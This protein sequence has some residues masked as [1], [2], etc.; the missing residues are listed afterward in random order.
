MLDPASSSDKSQGVSVW[1]AAEVASP[2]TV[3]G[4]LDWAKPSKDLDKDFQD[5]Y[6]NGGLQW[7]ASKD[8]VVSPVFKYEK[9][10]KSLT[11]GNNGKS[12][13]FGL[14]AQAKF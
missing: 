8:V 1:A 6:F 12:I 14:W 13:E 2:W 10:E 11:A 5:T 7:A 9:A 4:R 3:F